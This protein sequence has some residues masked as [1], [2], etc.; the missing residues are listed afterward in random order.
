LF[1]KCVAL[2]GMMVD[3]EGLRGQSN[4]NR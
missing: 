3:L 4:L 2:K 1:A